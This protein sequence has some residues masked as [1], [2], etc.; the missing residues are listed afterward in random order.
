MP[1]QSADRCFDIF[2][3]RVP[4]IQHCSD[5][6][7][8]LLLQCPPSSK[9]SPLAVKTCCCLYPLQPLQLIIQAC[10]TPGSSCQE[11]PTPLSFSSAFQLC[12]PYLLLSICSVLLYNLCCFSSPKPLQ[13]SVLLS[14]FASSILRKFREEPSSNKDWKN[15]GKSSI[16]LKYHRKI[17]RLLGSRSK[18]FHSKKMWCSPLWI[19]V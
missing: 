9:P 3:Q 16:I 7:A 10:N 1:R 4:L 14:S 19:R 17:K 2:L 5:L 6:Q 13:L 12:S 18:Y 11:I 8:V 15:I